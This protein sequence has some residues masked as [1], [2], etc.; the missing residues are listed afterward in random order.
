MIIRRSR[1]LLEEGANPN[2]EPDDYHDAYLHKA[3]ICGLTDLV[4]DL[5]H[6]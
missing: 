3:A 2:S 5:L 6:A 1:L 4:K